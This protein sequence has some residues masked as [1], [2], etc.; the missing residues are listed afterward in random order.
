M[1]QELVLRLGTNLYQA[2][3]NLFQHDLRLQSDADK[4]PILVPPGKGALR[5]EFLLD[6]VSKQ[7]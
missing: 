5:I 7:G 3:T 1:A 6:Y 2:G 4:Q